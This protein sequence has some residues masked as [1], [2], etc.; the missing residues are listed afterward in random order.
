VANRLA[1]PMDY[2]LGISSATSRFFKKTKN[3]RKTNMSFG[4]YA[5]DCCLHRVVCKPVSS[6]DGCYSF[7]SALIS[8]FSAAALTSPR[9]VLASALIVAFMA[10]S[11]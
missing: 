8:N 11:R 4:R 2:D 5:F 1:R 10:L 7:S 6:G 3:G 9:S